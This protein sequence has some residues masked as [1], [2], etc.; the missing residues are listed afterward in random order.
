V[1]GWIVYDGLCRSALGRNETV[2]AWLSTLGPLGATAPSKRAEAAVTFAQVEEIVISRCS[3]CHAA[4]PV[5]MGYVR[6]PHGVVL[7]TPERIKAHA[8]EI[9][10]AAVWSSAMP[11]SNVTGM[12]PQE[13]ETLAAWLA[14]G[15]SRE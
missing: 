8:R 9:A 12:T 15:R 6:P 4:E 13:R 10:L 5:W 14:S 2:L 1:L 3:M 7:D 11:P